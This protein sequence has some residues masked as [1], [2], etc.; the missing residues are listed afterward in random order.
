MNKP[1]YL[2]CYTILKCYSKHHSATFVDSN[3]VC[4]A[5]YVSTWYISF[6][7]PS[8]DELC[9][10]LKLKNTFNSARVALPQ[11]FGVKKI[12]K[13]LPQKQQ[14]LLFFSCGQHCSFYKKD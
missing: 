5:H 6:V 3:V 14:M 13:N 8:T 7:H 4:V 10:A 12:I 9:L 2:T 11:W 1:K